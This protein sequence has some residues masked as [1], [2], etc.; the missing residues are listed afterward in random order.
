M[1]AIGR[2]AWHL[3]APAERT[4]NPWTWVVHLPMAGFTLVASVAVLAAGSRD[5]PAIAAAI[6]VIVFGLALSTWM[7][8]R[9]AAV[10][11]EARAEQQSALEACQ[12]GR[13]STCIAGLDALCDGVL[14]IWAGQVDLARSHTAESIDALASRFANINERIGAS[15]ASSQGQ[16]GD[17]LIGMLGENE[18]ELDS[19]VSTLRSALAMKETMLKEVSSL[20]EITD[21][22]KLMAKDVGDIAKQTNLL[23]LNAAIEA[24]RAGASGAGFAVV[25]DEVRKLSSLSAETGK[26]IGETVETANAAIE[27]TLHVSQQFALQDAEMIGKS[28]AA[29]Q[30]V[31]DRV[32]G[33]VQGLVDASEALRQQ[34]RAI[35]D[36]IAEVLVA[37]Q[38]QDRVSQVLS[39]VSADIGKLSACITG[40]RGELASGSVSGPLDVAAWL[41]EM[42]RSYT[43]PEQHV[44]HDGGKPQSGQNAEITFF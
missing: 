31:V 23:A 29:I 6:A 33:A 39:H 3:A 7:A 4:D 21:A 26:K 10:L 11:R 24:A 12:C 5:V 13:K 35:G 38:F 16:A 15:M 43:V 40:K 19:I 9:C 28:E 20:A 1:A 27:T 8:G 18:V 32:H 2:P 17:S 25:A 34:N 42:E 41:S 22:L 36:E 14:P 30:R 37:L 44:I